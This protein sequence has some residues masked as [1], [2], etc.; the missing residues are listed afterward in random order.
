MPLAK[1]E[2]QFLVGLARALG[3]AAIFALPLLLTQ[4]MWHLGARVE[5]LRLVALLAV[6]FP[7]L[8]ALSR[9]YGFE[10]TTSLLGDLVDAFVAFGVGA[11]AGAVVL[12]LF[13]MLHPGVALEEAVAK[14]ALQAIPG[15]LGA[16]LAMAQL[17]GGDRAAERDVSYGAHLTAMAGGALF[18]ALNVAPTEEVTIIATSIS[19]LGALLL[20]G[21]SLAGTHAFVFSLEFLGQVEIPEGHREISVFA[22]YTVVGYAVALA[23]S[24]LLLWTFGRF[25]GIPLELMIRQTIV[26]GLPA[27]LGAAAA[28]LIL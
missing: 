12:A 2:R 4:E 26:L 24:A 21:V 10:E 6:T 20:A 23:V 8:V 13:G 22:R 14:V 25:D 19:P 28:R 11:L 1:A 7:L 5:P 17:G 9:L 18:L 16:V 15:A 27:A 3:G